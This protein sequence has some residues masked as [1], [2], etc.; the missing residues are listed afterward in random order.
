MNII[1]EKS[2]LTKGQITLLHNYLKLPFKLGGY[3]SLDDVL[4]KLKVDVVIESGVGKHY[5]P[6]FFKEAIEFWRKEIYR[7]RSQNNNSQEELTNEISSLQGKINFLAE[8]I[9]EWDQ[10]ILRGQYVSERNTISLYPTNMAREYNGKRVD[11]L[12]LVTFARETMHAY[13]NRPRHKSFP[14]VPLVEEPLAELGML[15]YL[16]D[17]GNKS[18][19]W[20]YNDV[21]NKNTCHRYGAKLMDRCLAESA[22]S[23]TRSYLESYKLRHDPFFVPE[24]G[25]DGAI[26]LPAQDTGD[27]THIVVDGRY[28]HIWP[29]DE[30]DWM[31][32]VC[33]D[34]AYLYGLINRKG[35]ELVPRYMM[36]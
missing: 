9:G 14:Y 18:Y 17:T 25:R 28:G 23:A 32:V 35:Q 4:T 24:I 29:C 1:D 20:A 21:E 33:D 26:D 8:E 5:V 7:L 12:L 27:S 15:L 19:Q 31:M 30:N 3:A 34:D 16:N 36:I 6:G 2:L 13:F 10:M 22:S 11:D